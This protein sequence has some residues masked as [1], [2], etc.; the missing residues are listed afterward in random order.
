MK[1][2]DDVTIYN[3]ALSSAEIADLYN[4]QKDAPTI[5]DPLVANYTFSG[6]TDDSSPYKNNANANGAQVSKDR[7]DNAN[8]AFS[9]DG[10][11]NEMTASI[12]NNKTLTLLL[13][14]LD[15][16]KEYPCYRRSIYPF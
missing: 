9:F 4:A 1:E 11:S 14:L 6:N 3:R 5:T 13:L 8:Q 12:P 16:C 10:A 7:F 15:Q 2:A